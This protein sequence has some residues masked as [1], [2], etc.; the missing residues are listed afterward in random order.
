MARIDEHIFFGLKPL[1]LNK[2]PGINQHIALGFFDFYR[3]RKLPEAIDLTSM[4]LG[5]TSGRP[6]HSLL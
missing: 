6:M 4:G 3:L 1:G 5:E 2:K